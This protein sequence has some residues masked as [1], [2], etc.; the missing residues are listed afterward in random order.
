LSLYC[1]DCTADTVPPDGPDEYYIVTDE[2][3]A[4]AGGIAG[5]SCVHDGDL[6][7]CIGC[8]EARVGRTLDEADFP[9]F[10]PVNKPSPWHT[11]RLNDRL[12][13]SP[14]KYPRYMPPPWAPERTKENE[15]SE[16]S[17]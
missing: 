15:R 17:V 2:V 4:E 14:Q 7:L 5:T 11:E 3:W 9:S 13:W 16:A 8:L 1:T 12:G 10:R 6:I